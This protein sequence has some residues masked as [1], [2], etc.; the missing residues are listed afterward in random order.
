MKAKMSR[1]VPAVP[2]RLA[3]NR[4]YA[5]WGGMSG[6]LLACLVF[7]PAAWLATAVERASA[8]QVRLVN[9]AGTIWNGSAAW[10]LTSGVGG[11][12]SLSLPSR[13]AWRIRP[14][15]S[16]LHV[17]L[18]A[19]CCTQAPVKLQISPQ[20]LRIAA[21]AAHMPM[22]LLQGLGTPWNTLELRGDLQLRWENFAMSWA[23]SAITIEG[24]ME[25]Q[26]R[27]VASRLSPLPD[28]GSYQLHLRGGAQPR[29]DLSTLRGAL[30]LQ[31]H[32]HW[33]NAKFRFE[34]E[35]HAQP[36]QATELANLLTLLGTRRGNTTMIRWG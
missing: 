29:V 4:G 16:G 31:G 12:T 34:G 21:A 20:S 28:V 11:S 24:L 17:A 7:A 36:E 5:L 13:V 26:A 1:K 33:N 27:S 3:S 23:S 19:A 9:P 35:A 30:V 14:N 15:G 10:V 8:G 18:D 32:G 25:M 6:A 2:A 22:S